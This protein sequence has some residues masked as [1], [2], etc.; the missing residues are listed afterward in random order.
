M[1]RP[2]TLAVDSWR[3]DLVGC[4]WTSAA[5]VL[6]FHRVPVLETL[7]AAWGFRH[8][9]GDLRREEYYYPTPPGVSLYQALA[10]YH[11]VR[12]VWHEP[13]DAE[14]GW[15]Q[16]RAEVQAGKPTV[17]AADNFYLPFRPAY[18]DVHTN[19]L[20]VVYGYDEAAGT[21]RVLD[22]VPPH[23]DGDITL[24]EL[25]AARDSRNPQLH[26][27]DMFFTD[28]PIANRWLEVEIAAADFPPFDLATVRTTIRRNLDGFAAA[29]TPTSV[30]P[31]GS[32]PDGDYRGL[33]GQ[34]AYLAD[35]ADRLAGGADIRDELFLVAGA[36]LAN[37]A[38]HAEW[39]AL[40]GRQFAVPELAEAGRAVDRVAH[41][42][43][44][45]R[46]M[47][48]LTATGEV[49]PERLRR[50][51]AA[52]TDDQERALGWLDA[53]AAGP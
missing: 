27:R 13:A 20:I 4:L 40:A 48:A 23:F 50:R 52:L 7:G 51:F 29:G 9:P 6:S 47:S 17:V 21:V 8:L 16:V 12:S 25:A 42:W 1:T 45:V 14:Q 22:A 53:L 5:T 11:P 38:L 35:V 44:T 3:H 31:D 10:P 24:G 43:T 37:T 18:T 2:A 32:A 39:L 34:T 26:E 33:A 41:H 46:I 30:T 28:R 49:S 36:V 15:T 19:H